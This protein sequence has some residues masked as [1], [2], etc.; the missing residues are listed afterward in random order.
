M[1]NIS[2]VS[3]LVKSLLS[4]NIEERDAANRFNKFEQMVSS[5]QTL[6]RLDRLDLIDAVASKNI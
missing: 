6:V 2:K 1:V 3:E 5:K 4:Q